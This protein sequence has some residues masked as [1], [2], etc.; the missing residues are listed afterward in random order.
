MV[1]DVKAIPIK[2]KLIPIKPGRIIPIKPTESTMIS[3]V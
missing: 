2:P 3:P 1:S